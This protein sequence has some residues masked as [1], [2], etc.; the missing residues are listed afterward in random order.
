MNRTI[1]I[2][3]R[4]AIAATILSLAGGCIIVATD[5]R[6]IRFDNDKQAVVRD[7]E[8]FV[9]D[10]KSKTVERL[11]CENESGEGTDEVRVD[12]VTPGS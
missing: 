5:K 8:F 4:T 1:Q 7:G 10:L 11:S 12:V 2:A 6:P 3:L 9:V